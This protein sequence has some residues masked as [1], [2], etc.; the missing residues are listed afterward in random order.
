MDSQNSLN[1]NNNLFNSGIDPNLHPLLA[2]DSILPG[3][4]QPF[5]SSQQTALQS[6]S[7]FNSLGIFADNQPPNL[8]REGGS[9]LLNPLYALLSSTPA[10][11]TAILNLP[12]KNND[13]FRFS[14][15]AQFPLEAVSLNKALAVNQIQD[16]LNRPDRFEQFKIAFGQD[17]DRAMIDRVISDWQTSGYKIPNI[18]IASS[19]ILGKA[20]GGFD[21]ANNKIYLSGN[22]IGLGSSAKIVSVIIEEIGHYLDSKIHF[23][24]DA[25]GDEGEIFSKLVRGIYISDSEYVTLIHEDDRATIILNSSSVNIEQSVTTTYAIKA[26]KTVSFNCPISKMEVSVLLKPNWKQSMGV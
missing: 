19:L 23:N 14:P 8:P 20:D 5:P 17:L 25:T 22:L 12:S 3:L 18:E 2:T 13:P 1:T 16:F 26:E 21:T 4:N 10:V 24:G 7:H 6:Q 9:S 15:L 11:G